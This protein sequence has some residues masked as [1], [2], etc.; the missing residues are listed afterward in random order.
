[1]IYMPS[2]FRRANH[3]GGVRTRLAKLIA[4]VFTEAGFKATCEPKDLYPALGFWKHNRAD[5]KRW[6]GYI[7]IWRHGKMARVAINSWDSM[8]DCLKGFRIDSGG[9]F[10]FETS[11]TDGKRSDDGEK[12]YCTFEPDQYSQ[13]PDKVERRAVTISNGKQTFEA[14]CGVNCACTCG[15]CPYRGATVSEIGAKHHD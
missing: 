2:R 1:M 5:V 3:I 6:E 14:I 4:D 11:A 8:T 15:E 12:Y 13:N 7:S 9:F 10:D